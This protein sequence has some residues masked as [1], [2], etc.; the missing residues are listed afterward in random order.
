MDE[1]SWRQRTEAVGNT[2]FDR[3]RKEGA[4]KVLL[5]NDDGIYAPG[6]TALYRELRS[7][8]D[9]TV[10]APESAPGRLTKSLVS[11]RLTQPVSDRGLFLL[12]YSII[13]VTG[14]RKK[15]SS[16][17]PPPVEDDAAD[18]LIPSF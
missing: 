7:D 5:T 4:M 16:S 12:N 3:M 2:I 17:V 11:S 9:L 13:L 6:L 14:Y 8:F 1:Q 15:V 10:V 18:G